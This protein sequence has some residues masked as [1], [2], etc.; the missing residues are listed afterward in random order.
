MLGKPLAVKDYHDKRLFLLEKS[1]VGLEIYKVLG[2]GCFEINAQI[3]IIY[4]IA[5]DGFTRGF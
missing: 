2:N 3:R 1:L 5:Q 4:R